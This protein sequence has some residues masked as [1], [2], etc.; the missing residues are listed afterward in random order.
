MRIHGDDCR[1]ILGFE[2]PHSFRD[3]EFLDQVDALDLGQAASVKLRG[4]ADGVEIDG[5]EFF[6]TCQG[7]WPMP[8]LPI[9]ARM[10]KRLMTSAS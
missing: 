9:T 2:D 1:E 10:P 5:S 3:A 4:A 7:L 6:E 8:P